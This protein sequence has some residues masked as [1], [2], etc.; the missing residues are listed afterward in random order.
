MLQQSR[1]SYKS[2]NVA[3]NYNTVLIQI[4]ILSMQSVAKKEHQKIV[5]A[6]K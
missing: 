1:K 2:F 3:R 6:V 5:D 4:C